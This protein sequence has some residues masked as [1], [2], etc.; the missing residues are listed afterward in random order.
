[1]STS[2]KKKAARPAANPS[3]RTIQL[4][5]LAE[6]RVHTALLT[7]LCQHQDDA[8]VRQDRGISPA[9]PSRTAKS[10]PQPSRGAIPIYEPKTGELKFPDRPEAEIGA[11]LSRHGSATA[12]FVP[13]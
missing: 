9:T 2:T 1:M 3:Y 13:P 11:A 5:I 7:T 4:A 12:G 8:A 6:L 10:M